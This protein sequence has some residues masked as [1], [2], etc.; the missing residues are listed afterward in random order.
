MT[1]EEI[2]VQDTKLAIQKLKDAI[3]TFEQELEAGSARTRAQSISI[4]TKAAELVSEVTRWDTT[5]FPYP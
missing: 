3:D 4:A 2:A 1:R 5:R